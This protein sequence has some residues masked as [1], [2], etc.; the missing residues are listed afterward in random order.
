LI[1]CNKLSKF[2]TR[3]ISTIT[4]G[5]KLEL[6]FTQLNIG[7][8]SKPKT[9]KS[10]SKLINEVAEEDGKLKEGASKLLLDFIIDARDD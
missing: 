9:F 3:K 5:E 4:E 10:F 7:L 8:L 6:F 1:N 2:K